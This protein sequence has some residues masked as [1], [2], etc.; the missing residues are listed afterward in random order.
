[1]IPLPASGY[2]SAPV[3]PCNLCWDVE[4][5]RYFTFVLRNSAMDGAQWGVVV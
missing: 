2:F 1:M 4:S 3:P 5:R